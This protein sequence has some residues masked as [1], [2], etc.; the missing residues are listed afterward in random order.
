MRRGV[1]VML[2]ISLTTTFSM[3]LYVATPTVHACDKCNFLLAWGSSGRRSGNGQFNNPQ[4]IA[5]DSTGNIYVVDYGNYRVQ[6]FDSSGTY[7]TQWGSHGSGNGQF[8]DVDGVAV[9]SSG[10]VYVV[11]GGN[12]R[13]QKFSSDGKYLTQWG[14]YGDAGTGQ[15]SYPHGIAADSSGNVYITNWGDD[16]VQKFGDSTPSDLT[17]SLWTQ[18]SQPYL[19][20][21]II[22]V[23]II[24][25]VVLNRRRSKAKESPLLQ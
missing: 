6:K 23:G 11:D 3:N 5:S 1:L 2:L 15:F 20:L 25:I 7:I 13:V 19:I 8:R 9:D 14:S 16:R 17:R 12:Y 4:G 22:L 18:Y 24:I 21:P 10:N